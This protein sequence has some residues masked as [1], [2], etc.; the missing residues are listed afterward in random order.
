[1]ANRGQYGL[2]TRGAVT[3]TRG[4]TETVAARRLANGA[5]VV[6]LAAGN[7]HPFDLGGSVTF[8][9]VGAVD[10]KAC[11]F[12]ILA[13]QDATGGRAI[14]W[15]ASV[16]WLPAG[17]APTFTTTANTWSIVQCFTIDG[18]TTVFAGLA[19]TGIA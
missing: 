8:V 13:M 2:P 6:D 4:G 7:V 15:P 17:A 18:G 16:K 5:T 3:A 1:M 10:G 14:T 9:F 19:G 11:S 12:T